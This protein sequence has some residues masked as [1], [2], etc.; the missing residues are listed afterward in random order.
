MAN[1]KIKTACDKL[2]PRR[3]AY[4]ETLSKGRALGFRRE[5]DTWIARLKTVRAATT[6][7]ARTTQNAQL[8]TS[9]T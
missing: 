7:G 9:M 4:F 1:I 3:N 2:A 5:P 8:S 6:Q